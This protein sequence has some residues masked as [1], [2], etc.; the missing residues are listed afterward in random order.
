M[1]QTA[2]E[3][4][5]LLLTNATGQRVAEYTQTQSTCLIDMPAM[6]GVYLLRIVSGSDKQTG[7][8]VVY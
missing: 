1:Q 6:Q 7:K 4:L 3:T 5:H 8:I 2:E